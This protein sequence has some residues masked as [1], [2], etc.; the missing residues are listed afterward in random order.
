MDGGTIRI[1]TNDDQQCNLFI[2]KTEFAIQ[3]LKKIR[4]WSFEEFN[5]HQLAYNKSIVENISFNKENFQQ[6]ANKIDYS[7]S[8]GN[9]WKLEGMLNE[10]KYKKDWMR[11]KLSSK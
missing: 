1:F 2:M 5:Y 8:K 10:K 6:Q 7:F 11:V 4:K 9:D 3:E